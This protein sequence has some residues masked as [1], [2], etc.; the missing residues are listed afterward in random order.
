MSNKITA[1][2]NEVLKSISNI[3]KNYR[4]IEGLLT[5]IKSKELPRSVLA[6]LA[7]RIIIYIQNDNAAKKNFA[8]LKGLEVV[9]ELKKQVD[10][11]DQ[12][13]A[14]VLDELC[15]QYPEDLV[16]LFNPEYPA[17]IIKKLTDYNPIDK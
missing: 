10:S 11:N 13:L 9:W 15:Q 8:K 6:I 7:K 5:L 1:Q 3:L 2:E 17:I 16:R 12:G 4:D 14:A